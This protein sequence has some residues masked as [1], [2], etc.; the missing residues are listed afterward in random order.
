[1]LKAALY[2]CDTQDA[3]DQ[4]EVTDI[5]TP[6]VT[7]VGIETATLSTCIRTEADLEWLQPRGFDVEDHITYLLEKS[8]DNYEDV[9]EDPVRVFQMDSKNTFRLCAIIRFL[10]DGPILSFASVPYD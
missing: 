7:F 3:D 5:E 10:D 9:D 2:Y 8:V 4:Y 1:M 6:L